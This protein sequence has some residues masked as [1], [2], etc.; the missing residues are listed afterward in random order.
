VLAAD[1]RFADEVAIDAT[2]PEPD[3]CK[4]RNAS[5]PGTAPRYR[6]DVPPCAPAGSTLLW[7]YGES[8]DRDNYADIDQINPRTAGLLA[9]DG[10]VTVGPR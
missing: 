2:E 10:G 8:V 9:P 6:P 1:P 3:L 4:P 7:Q 5:G